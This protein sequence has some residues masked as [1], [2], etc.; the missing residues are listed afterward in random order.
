MKEI[1]FLLCPR[2]RLLAT[3]SQ[4]LSAKGSILITLCCCSWQIIKWGHCSNDSKAAEKLMGGN[5]YILW[6]LTKP[7]ATLSH[8]SRAHSAHGHGSLGKCV[9]WYHEVE[10]WGWT[11]THFCKTC[12]WCLAGRLCSSDQDALL[13][14]P[15]L[16]DHTVFW[17]CSQVQCWSVQSGSKKLNRWLLPP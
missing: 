15:R 16:S 2:W 17:W 9:L 14:P 1:I 5:N 6:K 8:L 11:A 4:V 3:K 10:H 7:R 12:S 13:Q